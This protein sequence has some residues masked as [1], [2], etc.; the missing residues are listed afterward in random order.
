MYSQTPRS[1][2]L[3]VHPLRPIVNGHFF[4]FVRRPARSLHCPGTSDVT[5][6][7]PTEPEMNLN[8]HNVPGRNLRFCPYQFPAPPLSA[9]AETTLPY[10][11]K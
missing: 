1:N 10:K 5:L 7:G 3:C 8:Q 4:F 11:Y 9:G 2:R 6:W